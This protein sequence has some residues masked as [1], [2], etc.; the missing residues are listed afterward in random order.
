MVD[1]SVFRSFFS[2]FQCC[3]ADDARQISVIAIMYYSNNSF[4]APF[5]NIPAINKNSPDIHKDRT[6]VVV[7]ALEL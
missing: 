2:C 6:K 7:Y 3:R 1:S 5:Q 4:S